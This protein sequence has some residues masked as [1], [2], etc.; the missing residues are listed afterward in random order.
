MNKEGRVK[1]KV[2][3]LAEVEEGANQGRKRQ[4]NET[5]KSK[6]PEDQS[7]KALVGGGGGEEVNGNLFEED[8]EDLEEKDT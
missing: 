5:Q 4:G 1:E 7:E 3:L 8:F 6:A 2:V